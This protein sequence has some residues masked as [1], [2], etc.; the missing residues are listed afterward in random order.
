MRWL[1]RGLPLVGFLAAGAMLSLVLAWFR[2]FLPDVAVPFSK[3]IDLRADL[4][5][6]S[7]NLPDDAAR[8]MAVEGLEFSWRSDGRS[9]VDTRIGEET[10]R[11]VFWRYG[12]DGRVDRSPEGT[13]RA[14]R[15]RAGWP[16][17]CVEGSEW[18]AGTSPTLIR[19]GLVVFDVRRGV[20]RVPVTIRPLGLW[21]DALFWG[22]FLALLAV[23]PRAVERVLRR[24][25]GLCPSCAYPIGA[26][27]PLDGRCSECGSAVQ[28]VR[29]SQ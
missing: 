25:Q 26:A 20:V 10:T 7:A 13:G 29:P 3:R 14:L 24:R 18:V 16:L 8:L 27:L 22:A 5:W 23:L 17:S 19:T 15:V 12:A 11:Y 2:V 21:V 6:L 1:K 4:R 9:F 28:R